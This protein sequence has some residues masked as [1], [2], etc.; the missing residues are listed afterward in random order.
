M[1]GFSG[2]IPPPWS[3]ISETEESRSAAAT[4]AAEAAARA[5]AP[6]GIKLNHNEDKIELRTIA[7]FR[8]WRRRR[9][10]DKLSQLK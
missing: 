4:A 6:A 5:A 8:V 2:S 1:A 3:S 10:L 7:N 9:R